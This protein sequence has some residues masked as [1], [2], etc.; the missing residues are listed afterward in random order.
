M[1][2][3]SAVMVTTISAQC[4]VKIR[5]AVRGTTLLDQKL[6]PLVK[7]PR[8]HIMLRCTAP[9][10]GCVGP[11][12]CEVEL[13]GVHTTMEFDMGAASSV[14]SEQQFSL[15]RRGHRNLVLS[16]DGLPKLRMY[17]GACLHPTGRVMVEVKHDDQAHELPLLV[18]PGYGPC[19]LGHDWLELLHLNWSRVHYLDQEDLSRQFPELFKDELGTLRGVEVKLH[20]TKDAT[21]RCFKARPVSD[22]LREKVDAELNRLFEDGVIKPV[23]FCDYAAP[24]VPVLRAN[25]RIRICGDYKLTVNKVVL[26]D[27]HPIPNIEDLYAKLA[28][29]KPHEQI[30]LSEESQK[31]TTVTTSRGL[32]C[33]TRLCQG[34]SASP[35]IFQRLM[36]QL[37]Q[38]IPMTAVYL[39]AVYTWDVLRR[40]HGPT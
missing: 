35:G 31:L 15:I 8:I 25:G 38:R 1:Q 12:V 28:G 29:G 33:Y 18:V 40:N 7:C 27:K 4:A 10:W 34:V 24:I 32:F 36:E 17:S 23:E 37:L 13:N 26:A 30:L 9:M 6:L 20:V 5:R 14:I 11:Y 21:V 22:A 3:V 16:K 39:D 19:L 2:S